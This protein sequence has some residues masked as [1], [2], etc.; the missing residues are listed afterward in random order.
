[1]RKL[2]QFLTR[3]FF[4]TVCAAPLVQAQTPTVVTGTITDANG[5]PYSFAKVSAQLI[6]TT[7]SPT[8][9]VGAIPKQIG[10]Q[11]N[12]T[13]DVNGTFSMNLFCNVAGGGCSVISPAGTQWQFTVT[14]PGISP[15]LGTGPQACSAS[16]TV[17]GASQSVSSNFSCPSL[18]LTGITGSVLPAGSVSSPSLQWAGASGVGFFKDASGN[19]G[20][21]DIFEQTAFTIGGIFFSA[22]DGTVNAVQAGLHWLQTNDISTCGACPFTSYWEPDPSFVGAGVPNLANMALHGGLPNQA[23]TI[24]NTAGVPLH[25]YE[26]L[27]VGFTS[28]NDALIGTQI[29]S[30]G[31]LRPLLFG[32]ASCVSTGGTCGRN[33]FGFVTIAAAATTVTVATTAVTALSIIKIGFDESIGGSLAVT[34]NT[35]AAS[36]SATYFVSARTPGT[37]FTIKTSSAPAVNPACLT[38]QVVN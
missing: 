23:I 9:I 24:F 15:P 10:G 2:S 4:L 17:T 20:F 25:V 35:A 5:L 28:N 16:V 22:G 29:G 19:I 34:C 18:T 21:G 1:M 37:S 8:V 32:G 26:R 7:A 11:Q 13:A 3:V 33:A 30:G 27:F 12:A 36:E 14:T 38:F 31:T 6:P